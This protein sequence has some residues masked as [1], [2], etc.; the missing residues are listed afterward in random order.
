MSGKPKK[1]S[2]SKALAPK[3]NQKRPR[4]SK[5]R[6]S[7]IPPPQAARIMQRYVAGENIRSIAR[8]EGRDRG[9]VSRIVQSEEMQA[10]TQKMR[11]QYYGLAELAMDGLRRALELSHDGKLAHEVLQN[12]G[13]IP[14]AEEL[15]AIQRQMQQT[16]PISEEEM[17]K[18]EMLKLVT[19]AYARAKMFNMPTPSL[20]D[21]LP[22]EYGE[23][24]ATSKNL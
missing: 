24:V 10:H 7:R 18:A 22:C 1:S 5:K 12:I 3:T 11:A 16:G 9:T 6:K 21:I 19:G 2:Q 17:V 15:S 20:D 14:S 4:A 8:D 23:G 13:V